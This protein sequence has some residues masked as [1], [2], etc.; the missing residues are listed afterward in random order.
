MQN[1]EKTMVP[2][3]PETFSALVAKEHSQEQEELD[4]LQPNFLTKCGKPR[5][6]DD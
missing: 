5:T 6:T 4:V 3:K 2:A 1:D